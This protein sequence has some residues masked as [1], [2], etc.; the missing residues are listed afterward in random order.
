MCIT[1]SGAPGTRGIIFSIKNNWDEKRTR[2]IG[3]DIRQDAV[4]RYLLDK[5]FVVPTP[6]EDQ[7]IDAFIKI[8]KEE[9]GIILS[10]IISFYF[11]LK[12]KSPLL[13]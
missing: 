13:P 3:T 1:A 9:S 2:L 8:C 4:G 5:F 12:Y 10:F 7:F 6:E 11:Y